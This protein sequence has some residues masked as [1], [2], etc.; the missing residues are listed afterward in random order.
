MEY[1]QS[2]RPGSI[3]NINEVY[4]SNYYHGLCDWAYA[5]DGL[6]DWA[7]ARDG[8]CDWTHARDDFC[9]WAYAGVFSVIEHMPGVV[10]VIWHMPWMISVIEHKLGCS[11]WLKYYM[12]SEVYRSNYYLTVDKTYIDNGSV[13]VECFLTLVKTN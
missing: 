12:T 7:Y 13:L 6:C 9:D 2:L 11:L 1:A 4:R 5:R 8:L 3:T 10:S